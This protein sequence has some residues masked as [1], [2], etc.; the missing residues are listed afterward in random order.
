MKYTAF[1]SFITCTMSLPTWERGL[2]LY[3][4]FF[5]PSAARSLPTWERG[6]KLPFRH[7]LPTPHPVAPH[8][9]AW[10]EICCRGVI[11]QNAAVAPHVGAWIEIAKDRC[12]YCT[13]PSLPTWERGL[14]CQVFRCIVTCKSRSPRGSVD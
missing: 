6:L 9:G 14:K 3:M 10:I 8:V 11:L 13:V 2:K 7:H 1:S 4:P 5:M 12:V